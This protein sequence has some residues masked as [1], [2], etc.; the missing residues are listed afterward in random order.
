MLQTA[1]DDRSWVEPEGVCETLAHA[2]I[3]Q[4]TRQQ[5]ALTPRSPGSA[6]R[7]AHADLQVQDL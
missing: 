6:A 1:T 5:G 2:F 3:S 4:R 7:H